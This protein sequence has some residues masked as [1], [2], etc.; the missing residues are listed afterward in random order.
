MMLMIHELLSLC[1]PVACLTSAG[2]AVFG[3]G[4]ASFEVFEEFGTLEGVKRVFRNIEEVI[5]PAWVHYYV[6]DLLT[7]N[8]LV[9]INLA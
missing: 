6:A 9:H 5:L 7:G 3:E 2:T 1:W 4:G 8:F